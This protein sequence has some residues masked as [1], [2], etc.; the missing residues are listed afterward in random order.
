[1]AE[2]KNDYVGTSPSYQNAANKTDVPRISDEEREDYERFGATPK[3][4]S[5]SATYNHGD[6]K[7]VEAAKSADSA[8]SSAK[9]AAS[10]ATPTAPQAPS[11]SK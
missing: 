3:P 7:E 4:E 2:K 8:E 5:P 11:T 6:E 9:S 10:S 1:M